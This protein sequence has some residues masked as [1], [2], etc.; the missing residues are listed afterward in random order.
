MGGD[1]KQIE[2]DEA[3]S[4]KKDLP[5]KEVEWTEYVGAKERGRQQTA[6]A[7]GQLLSGEARR[8]GLAL[9]P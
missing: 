6:R 1:H 7:R 3:V 8:A 2:A 9:H 4:R 5:R